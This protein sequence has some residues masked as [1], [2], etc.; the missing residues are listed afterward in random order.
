MVG[1]SARHRP[2]GRDARAGAGRRGAGRARPRG[3]RRAWRS[4][5][6]RGSAR[7]GCWPSC[8]SRAEERGHL[9]LSGTAAEF[10]RDV[11]FGV[12]VDALDEHVACCD[13]HENWDAALLTELEGVL[14][15]R[16]AGRQRATPPWPTSAT[17]PTARCAALL[18]LVAED[19]P[20]VLV[21]DD[22]HWG[23]RASIELV[24]ALLRR[25]PG[26]AGAAGASPSGPGQAPGAADGGAG[27][28]RRSTGSTLGRLSEAQ[29]PSC[30]ATWTS[31]R[32]RPSTATAAAT[33]STWSSWRGP[34]AGPAARARCATPGTAPTTPAACPP[35]SPRRWPRSWSALSLPARALLNG[36]A[37]AGEPFEPDLAAA[38]AELSE[39]E[40]LA[41]LD[42]LM[43]RD[44]VRADAACRASS[45][46]ATR[47]CARRCTSPRRGGWRLA[48]H[49]RAAAALARPRR[50][51]HRARAPRGAVG[52]PGRRGRGGAAAGGRPGI[53]R[54]R[55]G[56]GRPLV[57]RRA[58]P[59]AGRRPRAR[60]RG[61]HGAG[62]GP[63]LGG[64]AR[65][66]PDHRAGGHRAAARRRRGAAAGAD[67][68]CAPRW[69]T[70]WAATTT[71]TP[72]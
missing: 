5:A 65:G 25:G 66:L 14:P 53:R 35:R 23:D 52:R 33:R 61:A 54:A 36:A 26:R 34:A 18:E 15:P 51:R 40:G 19:S 22:L 31:A 9:V 17:A 60:V 44:L 29:A 56:G 13:P 24:A 62:L 70:G 69:S 6:S 47:W 21:L 48:A 39:E 50:R 42:D 68:R 64:R 16:R 11:P 7:R 28:A 45:S 59:A 67:H 58:A 41:A 1:L 43:D 27:R 3:R 38:V 72:A 46:S 30:W 4:R 49:A 32:W 37:V 57:R 71:P 8:A 55:A 2:I 12:W 20:L 63:A 10:E